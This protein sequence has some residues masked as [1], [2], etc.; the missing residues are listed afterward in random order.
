[1]PLR[2]FAVLLHACGLWK[3]CWSPEGRDISEDD[4]LGELLG[5]NQKEL[6]MEG[7]A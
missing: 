4:A 1:M 5:M 6:S 3:Q 2:C 7:K